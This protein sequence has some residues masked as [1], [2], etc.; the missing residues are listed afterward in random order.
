MIEWAPLVLVFL[1]QAPTLGALQER[2]QTGEDP[3]RLAFPWRGPDSAKPT[4]LAPGQYPLT[5]ANGAWGTIQIGLQPGSALSTPPLSLTQQG[6]FRPF[7]SLATGYQIRLHHG[8]TREVQNSPAL[9]LDFRPDDFLGHPLGLVILAQGHLIRFQSTGKSETWNLKET[10]LRPR[11]PE[12]P[13]VVGKLHPAP[14]GLLWLVVHSENGGL[15]QDGVGQSWTIPKGGSVWKVSLLGSTLHCHAFGPELDWNSVVFDLAGHPWV[16]TEESPAQ[17]ESRWLYRPLTPGGW[18]PSG[19]TTRKNPAPRKPTTGPTHPG[20]LTDAVLVRIPE[21]GSDEGSLWA[22]ETHLQ[23]KRITAT[24]LDLDQGFHRPVGEPKVLLGEIGFPKI[25]VGKNGKVLL[26]GFDAKAPTIPFPPFRVWGEGSIALGQEKAPER[27][28]ETEDLGKL[29][30]AALAEAILSAEET[31]ALQAWAEA[32]KRITRARAQGNANPLPILKHLVDHVLKEDLPERTRIRLVSLLEQS[33]DP[34]SVDAIGKLTENAP[35][36]V[37]ARALEA[38]AAIATPGDAPIFQLFLNALSDGDPAV[39]AQAA[40]GLGRVGFPGAPNALASALS[41]EMDLDGAWAATLRHALKQ[42]GKK[43]HERM[44]EL[45]QSGS[46]ADLERAVGYFEETRDPQAAQPILQLLASPHLSGKQ[47]LRLLTALQVEGTSREGETLIHLGKS[48]PDW[49]AEEIRAVWDSLQNTPTIR[50]PKA[51]DWILDLLSDKRE[52]I[53]WVVLAKLKQIGWPT[54]ATRLEK[55]A[56]T[57]PLTK[58]QRVA[59]DQAIDY[60]KKHQGSGP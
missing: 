27:T 43:G 40:M 39:K 22:L 11:N 47:P 15:W 33:T 37:R 53:R 38:L 34:Q 44:L 10:I 5:M 25:L 42:T 60:Q 41:F 58:A 46:D 1:A 35:S 50:S 29:G 48:H 26:G 32:A 16:R 52:E 24:L 14:D 23:Q 2:T 13:P 30:P 19:R 18:R 12:A 28:K 57:L 55:T 31:L 54:M 45:A 17:G 4:D 49:L 56:P 8:L 59:L 36:L 7:R 9:D 51:S 3:N 6:Q 21:E 20:S